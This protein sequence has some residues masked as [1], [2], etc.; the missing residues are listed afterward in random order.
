MEGVPNKNVRGNPNKQMQQSSDSKAAPPKITNFF[1]K[2]LVL[3]G[4]AAEDK[5]VPEH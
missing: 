3:S 2:N 1:K 5:D 4:Q